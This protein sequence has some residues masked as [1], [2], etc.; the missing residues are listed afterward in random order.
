M[1]HEFI[2]NQDGTTTIQV[3]FADEGVNL[4]GKTSVKGDETSALRYLP[5]FEADLRRN[6]TELFPLP[7]MPEGGMLE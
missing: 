4:Q 6:N 5:I 3:D 2:I 7:E 1:I